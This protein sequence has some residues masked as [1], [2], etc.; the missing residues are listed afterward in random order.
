[1]RICLDT[2]GYSAF[3]RGHARAVD[4]IRRSSEIVLTATVLG[5]LEAGFRRGRHLDRNRQ[6][7][8]RFRRSPRVRV[9]VVDEETAMC[10]AEIV[11]GL[12]AAG[13]PIP[14]NDVWIAAGAMQGGLRVL[15][16]DRHFTRIPQVAVE[17]LR[18]SVAG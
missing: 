14:T 11:S 18:P 4:L 13:S 1:M 8:D 17:L 16:S 3:K 15:T 7:L 12:R 9:A 2:S 10:Y 6:E 5:E